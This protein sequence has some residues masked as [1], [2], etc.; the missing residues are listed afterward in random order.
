MRPTHAG[1]LK[2]TITKAL[3]IIVSA[4]VVCVWA[5]VLWAPPKTEAAINKYLNYQGKLLNSTSIP[6]ADSSY[7]ITFKIYNAPTGG[8]TLWSDSISVST[9]NGLFSIL[10]GSSST[11]DLNFEDES[12]Y[13]LGVEVEGDGEMT[14]RKQIGAAAY[15]F[16]S[17]LL[18]GLDKT[19]AGSTSAAIVALDANGNLTITGNPQGGAITQGSVYI[20]P[21]SGDVANE[22]TLFGVAVSGVQ[23]LL[24]DEDGDLTVAGFVSTTQLFIDNIDVQT[25]ASR[26]TS[27]AYVIGV[28]PTN[29]GQSTST[30]VQFVLE[31]ISSVLGTVSGS[32]NLWTDS[33]SYIYNTPAGDINRFYDNGDILFDQASN[34]FYVSST[35]NV[36]GIGTV[37]PTAKLQVTGSGFFTDRTTPTAGTGVEVFYN[38]GNDLGEILSYDRSGLAY[39]PL[40]FDGGYLRFRIDGAE[41]MRVHTDGKVG[42]G[43]TLPSDLLTVMGGNIVA[44]DG[45]TSSTISGT[46]TSTFPFGATFATSGG[47]VGIGTS[48]PAFKLDISGT[49]RFSNSLYS[50]GNL[51]TSSTKLYVG[52]DTTLYESTSRTDSGAYF[53]G[54]DPTNIG[55]ST[56]TNVQFVLEDISSTLGTVSSSAN[57]WAL[58]SSYIYPSSTTADVYLAPT[59]SLG[60]GT[61]SP[62]GKLEV[63]GGQLSLTG[64]NTNAL[65]PAG[66]TMWG[67][68]MGGGLYARGDAAGGDDFFDFIGLDGVKISTVAGGSYERMRI[69]SSGYVGIGDTDPDFG[70]EIAASSTSG[71]LAISSGAG[72]D[73]DLFK[74][75]ASGNVYA[76]N[77]LSVSSTNLYIDTDT[78]LYESTSRTDSG[79]YFVGVDPTNIGQSTSTNVQFVL[80]DISSTLGTVSSSA[81]L[82][83]LGSSY[84]YPT[85]TTADVYLAGTQSLGIGTSS[86][87]STLQVS[88]GDVHFQ[89]TGGTPG[90]YWDESSGYLGIGTTA[91][92]N[93]LHVSNLG[94]GVQL[95]LS[96]MSGSVNRKHFYASSTNGELAFG[97]LSDDLSTYTERMRIDNA[98]SVGI[99]IS[100][101][102]EKFHVYG[103]NIRVDGGWQIEFNSDSWAMGQVIV[104]ANNEM[105]T[106]TNNLQIKT[107]ASAGSG[108][109]VINSDS[110]ALFEVDSVTGN[111]AI[112][113]R[114]GIGDIDPDFGLELAVSSTAGYLAISSGAGQDGDLFKIDASGNV[115]AFNNLSVSSTKLY[116]DTNTTLS[117]TTDATH[118][119]AYFVGVFDEFDWSDSTNVQAVLNDIDTTLTTVSSSANL[120]TDGGLFTYLT[121]TADDLVV[122]ASSSATAD[123]WLDVSDQIMYLG[124]GA[125]GTIATQSSGDL[126]LLPNGAGITQI[127]DAGSDSHTLNANDDLFISGKLEVDGAAYFD[128]ALNGYNGIYAS[129][130][131]GLYLGESGG[132]TYFR[133]Y[134]SGASV[135]FSTNNSYKIQLLP[136]AGQITQVGD[137]GSTSHVFN[138]NDDLFVSGRLEVDGISY[139]DSNLY[140]LGNLYTSST[141]LYVGSDTTLY[142][143]TSRTDS[144]AYFVGVDPTNIGQSTSTNV[145][146]V[147]EDISSVLGT[148]SG[149]A[150]LWT[151]AGSYIYN[152]PA[153]D[154]NRFYDNGDI[155]FDQ[156]NSTFYVSST[157]NRVGIGTVNPST[158]FHVFGEGRFTAISGTTIPLSVYN[159][160]SQE[161]MQVQEQSDGRGVL[162]L[163]QTGGGTQT[164]VL[165]PNG[166]SYFTGG[167]VGIGTN[168]PTS[169]LQVSGGDVHFQKTGGAIGMYWDENPGRLGIGTTAPASILEI[170]K[171]NTT[172][173]SSAFGGA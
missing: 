16:N 145:Q 88:G 119:G 156:A 29:I 106:G 164:I 120:W 121:A 58:G 131:T 5:G 4:L 148:V 140:S 81:N 79:A 33:G 130:A 142:E 147:L 51:Y 8:A 102:Q 134:V 36:V 109:Q 95:L 84:I 35:A 23:K 141:L 3:Y 97:E 93:E 6:V 57:L 136:N 69:T 61:T 152:T 70:L 77:N 66:L 14:P 17:D 114:V 171:E 123:L 151:D 100:N 46:A 154:I 76:F 124:G 68:N 13:Y 10:L 12:A 15:A 55:Q 31:D 159:S 112:D 92:N 173:Y 170:A 143:S 105:L 1:Q 65:N 129:A 41:K 104:S 87:T 90:M 137:A 162:A 94:T 62:T 83:S 169:T 85:S 56:S 54:V 122:G 75:D 27:G 161:M 107:F 72:Q 133:T 155:I 82:W 138:T 28:D 25:S 7:N 110:D 103:G 126:T 150:N 163:R 86:P 19:Q 146:F 30:N 98:G 11:I 52:A 32:A 50:L 21:A 40:S 165:D 71:Y 127:G 89:A 24:L 111:V 157:A 73:G 39:K 139:F 80:E 63:A 18:D 128:G 48:S 37:N 49:G 135:I 91:P 44:G 42:I 2:R 149:S 22:D 117:A 43:T 101:P 59:Q 45:S 99:G 78:T 108:F 160:T 168:S 53:V 153:G 96:D 116:I 125:T 144:G 166:D 167:E 38:T 64:V 20:N 26:T 67:G 74:I 34:T 158:I 172:A 115:Y 47:N 113:G 118:S 9:Q 132:S 60:I